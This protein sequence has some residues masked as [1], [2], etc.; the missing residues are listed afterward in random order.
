MD[1]ITTSPMRRRRYHASDTSTRESI[2]LLGTACVSLVQSGQGTKSP[3]MFSSK[4]I[5]LLFGS[6]TSLEQWSEELPSPS[7]LTGNCSASTTVQSEP[8]SIFIGYW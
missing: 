1:Q 2:A 7:S 3:P 6:W 5:H 4:R 8:E